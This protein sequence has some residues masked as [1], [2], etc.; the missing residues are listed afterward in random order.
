MKT[1]VIILSET[2]ASELTF[3]NVKKNLIDTLNADLCVCIGINNNYDFNNPF[4][5]LAKYHFTYNEPDD[6]GAAFDY[7]ESILTKNTSIK[8]EV[9]DKANVIYGHLN[10]PNDST[11][12][13]KY[14]GEYEDISQFDFESSEYEELV[15]HNDKFS[16]PLWRKKLYGVVKSNNRTYKQ[17]ENVISYKKPLKWREILKITWQI[18]GGVKDLNNQHPGSAGILIFFRWFLLHKLIEHDLIDKYDRFIITRSDYMYLSPHPRMETLDPNYIWIPDGE[19]YGG[20]TDRHTVLTPDTIRSYLDIFNCLVLKSSEYYL[21]ILSYHDNWWNLEKLIKFHL[22]QRGLTSRVKFFPYIM[23]S[24]RP[25]NGTTRWEKGKFSEE[26]GYFIK[27]PNEYNSSKKYRDLLQK[28]IDD[29]YIIQCK[30]IN[31]E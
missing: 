7:A 21:R 31:N 22:E 20:Y 5:K 2:R 8:Y 19:G 4:Y 14:L 11:D 26:H 3:D 1:L 6:Y 30:A 29:F 28:H 13:I 15:Y 16:D 27:Y 18:M 17:Q 25:I 10:N 9:L 24:V 12:N 23:Y